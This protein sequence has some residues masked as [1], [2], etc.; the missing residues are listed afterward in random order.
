MAW[1]LGLRLSGLRVFGI[2]ESWGRF[3]GWAS[4]SGVRVHGWPQDMGLKKE[5]EFGV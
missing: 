5:L 4:G 1:E 3:S 2:F